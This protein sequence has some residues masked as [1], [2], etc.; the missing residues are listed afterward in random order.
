MSATS[1][2]HYCIGSLNVGFAPRVQHFS[3]FHYNYNLHG[4]FFGRG[5]NIAIRESKI[6]NNRV[7]PCIVPIPVTSRVIWVGS[8]SHN[9]TERNAGV[10]HEEIFETKNFK[11]KRNEILRLTEMKRKLFCLILYTYCI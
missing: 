1:K 10:F 2:I 9:G 4:R 3:A 11:T 5:F 7:L 6:I 8:I